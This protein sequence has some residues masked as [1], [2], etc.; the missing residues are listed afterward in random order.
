MKLIVNSQDVAKSFEFA[1][2]IT[3][4]NNQSS[5]DFGRT[6]LRRSFADRIA[7]CAEGKIAEFGFVALGRKFGVSIGLDFKI[8]PS[9]NITDYGQDVE[10]VDGKACRYRVDIKATRSSSQWLLVERHKFWKGCAFVLVKAKLP[11]DLE[12][13]TPEQLVS[14]S[15]L[16]V[17]TEVMGFA[18][19]EDFLDAMN[20]P[21]FL[22]KQGSRLLS[23]SM[24]RLRPNKQFGTADKCLQKSQEWL[25]SGKIKEI[26]PVLKSAENFGY[27]VCLLRNTDEDWKTLFSLLKTSSF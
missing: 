8:Y 13:R 15:N 6:D 24:F 21:W 19:A 10:T 12:N 22:F 1:T 27:P 14:M 25:R 2:E 23:T 3:T 26:G 16:Q 4:D 20:Q 17:E 5:C 9:K 11:H 7:D 18:Y